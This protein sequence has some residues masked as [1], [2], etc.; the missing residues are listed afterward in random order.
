MG[1]NS[2]MAQYQA[3]FIIS[4]KELNSNVAV[5]AMFK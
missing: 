1:T 2:D 3:V 4:T 5:A